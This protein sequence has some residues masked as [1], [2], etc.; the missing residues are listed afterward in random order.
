MTEPPALARRDL[1]AV[2]GIDAARRVAWSR[3]YKQVEHNTT[4]LRHNVTLIRRL[5]GFALAVAQSEAVRLFEPELADQAHRVI[6]AMRLRARGRSIV[7]G[8]LGDDPE[9]GV[10]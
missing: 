10:P 3:Y 4:L 5:A 9:S 8:L 6:V 7:D 1:D 2:A